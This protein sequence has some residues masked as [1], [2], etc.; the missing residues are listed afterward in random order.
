MN[1]KYL[2]VMIAA[3]S[4]ATAIGEDRIHGVSKAG[5][6]TLFEADAVLTDAEVAVVADL[7]RQ[8]G[9][10]SVRQIGTYNQRVQSSEAEY[11]IRAVSE[12]VPSGREYKVSCVSVWNGKWNPGV[13]KNRKIL[14]SRGDFWIEDK[15]EVY[16]FAIFAAH[17]GPIRVHLDDSMPLSVAD[18]V[19]AA[20][21]AS[22]L[23]FKDATLKKSFDEIAK[24]WG[25][26]ISHPAAIYMHEGGKCTIELPSSGMSSGVSMVC[27]LDL[28]GELTV[29]EVNKWNI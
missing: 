16:R 17:C 23:R 20:M 8:C 2:T 21:D 5:I 13:R 12:E 18:K 9:L 3:L 4:L 22:K 27:I 14:K 10:P 28:N 26:V 25:T 15:I 6:D 7:A 29:V 1:A 19:V 11:V 24:N